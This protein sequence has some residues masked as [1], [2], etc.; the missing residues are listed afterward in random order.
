[1]VCVRQETLGLLR[2][3]PRRAAAPRGAS[4]ESPAQ[5]HAIHF[6]ASIFAN[7]RR[8]W[9]SISHSGAAAVAQLLYIFIFAAA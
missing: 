6:C 2:E 5:L 1:M 4:D 3:A 7:R 8:R 9:S